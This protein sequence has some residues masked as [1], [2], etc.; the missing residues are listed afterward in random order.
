MAIAGFAEAPFVL[1]PDNRSC[2]FPGVSLKFIGTPGKGF[3]DAGGKNQ[4]K[5]NQ[6]NRCQYD[7]RHKK[8]P[9][10]RRYRNRY[11]LNQLMG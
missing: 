6:D 3:D 2:G 10:I 8:A 5:D 7:S 4:D 9:F 11:T 1:C